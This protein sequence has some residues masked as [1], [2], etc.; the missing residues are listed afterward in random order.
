MPPGGVNGVP[1]LTPKKP[2]NISFAMVVVT[3]GAM[4]DAELAFACPLDAL[5]GFVVSTPVYATMPP[6]ALCDDENVH[7]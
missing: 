3:D 7:V 5:I 4:T 6:L 1:D 2:I